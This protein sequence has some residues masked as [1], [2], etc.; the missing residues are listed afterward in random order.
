MKLNRLPFEIFKII[1]RYSLI[2][3]HDSIVIGVSGGPDSVALLKI[4]HTLNIVKDL[5]LHLIVAHLNHQL[6]GKD[7]SD[8]VRFVE[9]LS[10]DLSLP[11][12]SKNVNIQVLSDQ[13]KSS[14]EET[15]RRER[16]KFFMELSLKHNAIS[17]ATGHNADDNVET[18]LHRIIRGTGLLG[19]GGIPI[20]RSLKEDPPIQLIRPLLFTWR[21]EIIAYL[22]REQ[23]HYRI[24]KSNYETGYFRNRIRIELIPLLENRFN[25]NIKNTLIQLC[26]IL[27]ANNEYLSSEAEKILTDCTIESTS[28]SYSID[29]NFLR[30]Q[31]KVLQHVVLQKILNTMNVPLKEITYKHYT[32]ILNE[33]IKMGKGRYFQFPGRL[34]SWY[35]HRI[36]YFRKGAL[37]KP[38]KPLIS[39]TS[40]RIP[41]V[42]PIYPLGQIVSEIQ[43]VRD[44]SLETF[45]KHKTEYEEAFDLQSIIMPLVVRSRKKG[46]TVSPLGMDGHKKLKD[47]FI[48]KKVPVNE[49]DTIP[50]VAMSDHPIWVIGVCID[51][52]VKIN[53]NTKKIVKLTFQKFS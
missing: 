9:N 26:Q 12:F 8:D 34:Y 35:E 28:D 6:R 40:I 18:L 46:D 37:F 32:R 33:I 7:S 4:L 21:R 16:Y 36:L 19:L 42:T 49:R 29:V 53:P 20:K 27:N 11:F 50:V 13:T 39:G 38:Y 52:R 24:D 3:L 5:K 25:P 1:N 17:V 41:G 10:R 14:I 44:F 15:A 31:P 47:L 48:D 43:D 45:K 2:K 23:F 51:R 22:E 30:K